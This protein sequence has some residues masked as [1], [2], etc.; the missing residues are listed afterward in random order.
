[1]FIYKAKSIYCVKNAIK[2]LIYRLLIFFILIH[3]SFQPPKLIMS[4]NIP[5]KMEITPLNNKYKIIHGSNKTS[6]IITHILPNKLPVLNALTR[7]IFLN[8]LSENSCVINQLR[9]IT[10]HIQNNP[11]TI[12]SAKV[13]FI[14]ILLIVNIVS[15]KHSFYW[16]FRVRKPRRYVICRHTKFDLHWV[17]H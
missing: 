2:L 10:N 17:Y 3:C 1:M 8:I 12:F 15:Q 4:V 16:L 9:V 11:I 6:A 5:I 13:R 14:F 7:H